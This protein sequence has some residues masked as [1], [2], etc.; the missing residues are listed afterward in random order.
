MNKAIYA[1][2]G[3]PITYGHLDIIKRASIVFDQ[4]VVA[5][6]N[7]SSK[8]YLFS[9]EERTKLTKKVLG[10]FKNIQVVSFEG[11]LVDFAYEQNIN[12]IIRG[13]RNSTD[14]EYENTL[15]QVGFSQKLNIDTFLLFSNPKLSHI[16][17]GA[18]K[19]LIKE[20]GF[21]Q[22]Y[23]P[24]H[25]K[26]ALELKL[27]QQDIIGITGEIGSG[28]S[29]LTNQIKE[30]CK[31]IECHNIDLDVIGHQILSELH[32]PMYVKIRNTL[33][34]VFGETILD[35]KGNIDRKAL[36]E[37]VFNDRSKLNKLNDIM[38]DPML[39]RVKREMFG[40]KGL[41][42]LNGALLVES[43]L[44]DLCN[45]NV[46][47]THCS[48]EEHIKR[49]EKRGYDQEKIDRRIKSQCNF[50]V[51]RDR[52]RDKILTDG[53]GELCTIDTTNGVTDDV[54]DKFI[55]NVEKVLGL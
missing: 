23:V 39:V 20:Q 32:E 3:D 33:V 6:G 49:L 51:K 35:N 5:I 29:F 36:G 46:I 42:L 24:L 45:N 48:K 18:V 41:I 15:H 17:S 31:N 38:Y 52:V 40:K 13:I 34:D 19:A 10:N 44:L 37:I 50:L 53:F 47:L 9:L 27:N 26:H 11:L 43:N 55:M 7:N 22:E 4:L 16:S 54:V 14:M 8:K 25:V 28:K 12:V 2:S 21:I 1:F 30:R